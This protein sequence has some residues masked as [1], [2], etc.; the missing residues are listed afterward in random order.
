MA[1]LLAGEPSAAALF[2]EP[3]PGPFI[4][5]VTTTNEPTQELVFNG[6]D[7]ASLQTFLTS[8]R[9][10]FPEAVLIA[11]I[12]GTVEVSDTPLMVGSDTCLSL[13]AAGQFVPKTGF[14][15]S[16]LIQVQDA[17][18]VSITAG[19][20]ALATLDGMSRV[21]TGILVSNSGKVH[22][23]N[24][25]LQDFTGY[26]IDY[27]GRGQALLSDAGS[28]TR[29][30]IRNSGISGVRTTDSTRFVLM[31]NMVTNSALCGIDVYSKS[32]TVAGNACIRNLKGIVVGV[33]AGV[34]GPDGVVARNMLKNNRVGLE[35]STDTRTHVV[36]ENVIHQNT[37]GMAVAGERNH[38]FNND[39]DNTAEFSV[40]GAENIIARHPGVAGSEVSGGVGTKFFNPPTS[41]HP[42][43][44][45]VIVLGMGRH[46]LTFTQSPGNPVLNLANVQAAAD[47][48]R[49]TYPND[50]I[51]LW[52]NGDFVANQ[53]YTGL[54]LPANTCVVLN[55]T[56]YPEG[57]GMDRH[58]APD[59]YA[60]DPHTGGTQLVLMDS[61]GFLSF[62]GGTLDC[63]DLPAYGIYAPYD[64]VAV[65]DGVTVRDAV[66]NNIGVLYHG[67]E[68][69]PVF[70]RGCTLDGGSWS[71][72]RGVWI[73]VC[74]FIH[75]ISNTSEGHVAD[76]FDIDAVGHWNK[77]L[78]NRCHNEKRTGVFIEEGASNNF[79]L[80]NEMSGDYG[81]GISL[82]NSHGGPCPDNIIVGNT[83]T[84]PFGINVRYAEDTFAFNNIIN[85]GR[86][87][88]YISVS[89]NYSAQTQIV[90]DN[91][92]FHDPQDNP[93]FTA[94][95]YHYE[96][97]DLGATAYDYDMGLN[98]SPVE[99]GWKGITPSTIGDISWTGGSV[100]G[101]Y[102]GTVGGADDLQR[103]FI[104]GS[105]TS[106]F[107]HA[108]S[109]GIWR[110]TL[111]MGD[112]GSGHDDMVVRAEGFLK[113]TD[114]DAAPGSFPDVTF[115]VAVSDRS[116]TMEISDAGGTD[117]EWVLNRVSLVY[118]GAP[119]AGVDSDGDGLDDSD[120]VY[121]HGT[122]PFLSD[123]DFDG[124]SDSEELFLGSSPT[125]PNSLPAPSGL[126]AYYPFDEGQGTTAAD[127]ATENGA[128]DAGANQGV[129]GW[130]RSTPLIGSSALD[131]D[132]TASMQAIDAVGVGATGL[133]I[134]VWFK[135]AA[136]DPGYDGVFMARDENWGIAYTG[137][138]AMSTLPDYRIDNDPGGGST[139]IRPH[140]APG[141]I[142]TGQWYHAAITW[143][144]DGSVAVARSYLDGMPVATI[145]STTATSIAVN[146]TGHLSW[147]NIG[148]D[149]CCGGREIHAVID[150]LAVFNE[151][152][153]PQRIRR[154]Y[155]EGIEGQSV[156][157]AFLPKPFSITSANLGPQTDSFILT[158]DSSG[159]APS[160]DVLATAHLPLP[161][162]QWDLLAPGVANGGDTTSYTNTG[163]GPVGPARVFAVREAE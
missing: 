88:V 41:D 147:W 71:S 4:K 63:R 163:G 106:Q 132:G 162:H 17:E 64:A 105:G 50:V 92:L 65:I 54:S 52:L 14:S 1:A 3:Q 47:S 118:L 115:D 19:D 31:D 5:D 27:S 148:D 61:P 131:L 83:V 9:Y 91:Y 100:Y 48:A 154:I 158:W 24:L 51:V 66:D 119:L 53:E 135:P 32:A 2:Q 117:T 98:S 26:G 8:S 129:V 146:Y 124:F 20:E 16:A 69:A 90:P 95:Y 113:A 143:S 157:R 12:R 87:G 96:T 122:D 127:R 6:G 81:N 79:V 22:I 125:D 155:E 84:G 57:P 121:T 134:S 46:D 110:V 80:G 97:V 153:T 142:V 156:I 72:N 109:N 68:L 29:C 152:L 141:S 73:H 145:D 10:Y 62:S 137:D 82:Y 99:P 130:D 70:I 85:S 161:L 78:F 58:S 28:V 11:H 56:I 86:F 139:S 144:T 7:V 138:D 21:G 45:P 60:K 112:S 13:E 38:I 149:P 55:G 44:D 128:Q 89:N 151:A 42:H 30:E 23:D 159:A 111:T 18:Y 94:A 114:V 93:F 140:L 75:C 49:A 25:R 123:S 37:T 40:T 34:P 15:P 76:S 103:D 126:V 102:R 39:M 116:L 160:Y 108:I 77:I 107:N 136:S 104:H 74:S 67:H 101:T 33:P 59:H 35:L 120:E 36:T 43:A 150:D 133:T